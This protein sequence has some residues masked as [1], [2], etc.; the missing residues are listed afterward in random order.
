MKSI[1]LVFI[2]TVLFLVGMTKFTNDTNYNEA[3][4]YAELSQ[5]YNQLENGNVDNGGIFLE[6]IELEVN[7]EGAVKSTKTIKVSYGTYLSEAI[8]KMGG[9]LEEADL[10]CINK[11][12][13]ILES[14]SFYIPIGKNDDKVSINTAYEDELM[15]LTSVGG[16]TA[17]RI[18]EYRELNGNYDSLEAIMNVNGIGKQTFNKIKDNIIL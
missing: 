16:I 15:T 2:I 1:F 18:I 12:K 7:F 14:Q 9:L 3:I 4:R 13:V 11:N 8:E 10:R 17:S 6:T 5:Y